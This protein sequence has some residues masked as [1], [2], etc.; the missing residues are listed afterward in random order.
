MLQGEAEHKLDAK[1]RI[2]LPAKF[3]EDFEDGL[4]LCR[5]IEDCLTLYTK[6]GYETFRKEYEVQDMRSADAR[7]IER[8][9][10]GGAEFT[11]L[12]T[13]GRLAVTPVK[14]KHAQIDRAVLLIGLGNRVEMWATDVYEKAA[15][16]SLSDTDQLGLSGE[17]RL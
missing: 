4:W 13:Q 5:G 6:V 16:E 10:I 7:W 8:R 2:V 14:R 15:N 1:G 3:R 9:V 12:D 11:E 17:L